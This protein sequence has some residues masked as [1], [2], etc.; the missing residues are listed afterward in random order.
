VTATQHLER[1]A[2]PAAAPR[3]LDATGLDALIFALRARGFRVLGP[4]VAD[5]AIVYEPLADASQLPIGWTDVQEPGRYRL[6][7]RDDDARFGYAVGPHSWKEH[8]FPARLSLF[9]ATSGE[10]ALTVAED[11]PDLQPTALIG[12]RACE[13]A[14]IAIQDRVFM[15]GRFV[16]RDYVARRSALFV[17]AVDC[18][19]PASTC[20][21]D[22]VGAG[23]AVEQG[24]D[25]RL[26]ELLSGE[27]RFLVRAGTEVGE[28]LLREL[29]ARA[30]EDDDLAAAAEV[31]ASARK[32]MGAPLPAGAREAV[33]ADPEHSRWDD[34][35]ARC[36]G[37]AN[38]TLVCPTCFCSSVEDVADLSG[39]QSERIRVWDSCFSVEHSELHGGAVRTSARSRYRQWLTHKLGTWPDQFGTAGCV[40]CGRCVTWCPAGIDL[41]DEV[42]ALQEVESR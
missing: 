13:L 37:C 17:V 8:L 4:T 30:A 12:V 21:C 16:D 36:L 1:S 22:S 14:A 9:R 20:F 40:G 24:F 10:G 38:C 23:P 32:R 3:V 27:H 29:P 41:R 6:E 39:D 18:G 26:T 33:L 31:T 2:D 11:P 19:D 42:R 25:L 7:R 28:A 15:G 34:V 35:A 5:G